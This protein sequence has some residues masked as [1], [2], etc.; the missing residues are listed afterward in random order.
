MQKNIKYFICVEVRIL[1][2]KVKYVWSSHFA[3]A[4]TKNMQI[5]NDFFLCLN[6]RLPINK[7]LEISH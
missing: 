7:K 1:V 4:I 5:G 6:T 3:E 2:K